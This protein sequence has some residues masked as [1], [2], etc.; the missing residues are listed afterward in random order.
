MR[1]NYQQQ[2]SRLNRERNQLLEERQEYGTISRGKVSQSKI[3]E[4]R[5]RSRS[6][7]NQSKSRGKFA[8]DPAHLKELKRLLDGIICS[9][10][11][12]TQ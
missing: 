2:I 10:E 9:Q 6:R 11:D 8:C 1:P 5:N 12:D 7:N 3:S 4:L